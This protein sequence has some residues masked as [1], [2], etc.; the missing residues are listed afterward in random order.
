MTN[1]EQPQKTILIV[2]DTA[3][4]ID[5]LKGILSPHYR[6]QIATNGRL[7]LKVAMSPATPD[8]ILLDVMMPE[9]DGY[10]TFKI[11]KRTIKPEIS[12]FCL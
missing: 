11:L 5:V 4:N 12:R 10:E 9:M 2:D 6:I 3:E 8:L 1:Q 7:A